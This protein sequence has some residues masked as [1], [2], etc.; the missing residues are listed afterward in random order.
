MKTDLKVLNFQLILGGRKSLLAAA[1][2]SFRVQ[3]VP[4]LGVVRKRDPKPLNDFD[5]EF[6]MRAYVRLTVILRS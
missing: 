3:Y 6:F 4:L 2:T 5:A 1:C